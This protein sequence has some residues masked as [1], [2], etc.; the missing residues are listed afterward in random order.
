MMRMNEDAYWRAVE[1]FTFVKEARTEKPK[2]IEL[3]LN[4]IRS[5][6]ENELQEEAEKNAQATLGRNCDNVNDFINI[7]AG[8]LAKAIANYMNECMHARMLVRQAGRST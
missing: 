4:K 2:E 6:G 3:F 5:L 7:I 8:A 1:P